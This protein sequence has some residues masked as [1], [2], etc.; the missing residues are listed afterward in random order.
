[1]KKIFTFLFFS[2][3]A[4]LM[5]AQTTTTWTFDTDD[6]VSGTYSTPQTIDGL[7][8]TATSDKQIKF[9]S[10][11]FTYGDSTYTGYVELRGAGDWDT[12]P[13]GASVSFSV[14]GACSIY[15]VCASGGSSAR[16]LNIGTGEDAVIDTIAAPAKVS[17][18][19]LNGASV[20]YTGDGEI[21]YIWSKSSS[22]RLFTII[23]TYG[24]QTTG[25]ADIPFGAE[26]VST[27]YYNLSG[28]IVGSETTSLK[29]GVYIKKVTYD[30][31]DVATS[32]VSIFR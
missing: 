5:N 21:I 10:S 2:F 18:Y 16:C 12:T 28:T 9:G 14:D 32:K 31:G 15:V 7:T 19:V 30:T 17:D 29:T 6:Y 20:S 22:I 23:V 26:V 27:E 8:F 11:T 1:M 13:P 24:S 25:I 4:L 3:C